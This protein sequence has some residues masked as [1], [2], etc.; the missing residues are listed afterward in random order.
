MPS[1]SAVVHLFLILQNCMFWDRLR[2]GLEFRFHSKTT[3]TGTLSI[4]R[5]CKLQNPSSELR[6]TLLR[7]TLRLILAIPL[8]DVSLVRMNL[9]LYPILLLAGWKETNVR[10]HSPSALFVSTVTLK[11]SKYRFE[12]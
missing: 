8:R 4:H 7:S 1:F 3:K 11:H 5:C 2:T 12:H 9:L 6:K 10:L